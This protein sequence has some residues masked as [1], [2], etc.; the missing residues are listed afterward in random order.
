MAAVR[1]SIRPR[2]F[3]RGS[4][5]ESDAGGVIAVIRRHA[6]TLR[7]AENSGLGQGEAENGDDR[8]MLA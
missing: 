4:R 2:P 8:G 3:C 1:R 6:A 5:S 7:L